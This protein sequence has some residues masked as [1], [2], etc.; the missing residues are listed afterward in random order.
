MGE[1]ANSKAAVALAVIQV[2]W[3][4]FI[5]SR[6]ED[7][8]LDIRK[9]LALTLIAAGVPYYAVPNQVSVLVASLLAP[10]ELPSEQD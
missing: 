10:L 3:E 8:L 5:N 6:G 7:W 4:A 9:E 1:Q 2:D